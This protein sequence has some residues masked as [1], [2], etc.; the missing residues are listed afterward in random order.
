MKMLKG[1]MCCYVVCHYDVIDGARP[2][3]FRRCNI[4]I[5]GQPWKRISSLIRNL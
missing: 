3:T 5:P 4:P 1:L 2:I